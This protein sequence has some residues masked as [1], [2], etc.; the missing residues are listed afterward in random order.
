MPFL[1]CTRCYIMETHRP[2]QTDQPGRRI[3]W[4]NGVLLTERNRTHVSSQS[5]FNQSYTASASP[6]LGD[7]ALPGTPLITISITCLHRVWPTGA[8]LS[9]GS[10]R[11]QLVLGRILSSNIHTED[12][13]DDKETFATR[14]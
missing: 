6:S 14:A 11:L 12:E 1:Q 7:S 3:G 13:C 5:R 8:G 4:C 2:W 9:Y 10:A